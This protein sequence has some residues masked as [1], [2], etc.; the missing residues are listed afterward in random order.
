[1]GVRKLRSAIDAAALLVQKVQEI[2]QSRK[3]AGAL[4][5]DVK[6]AFDHVS[7]AQL[8]QRMSDLGIDDDL[9]G[10]VMIPG[11]V[12]SVLLVIRT[13]L[14][15]REPESLVSVFVIAARISFPRCI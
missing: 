5:M 4:F 11:H 9:I 13:C 10:C 7:R 14:L 12:L 1:M 2:W 6:G 15:L 8:A 3:I